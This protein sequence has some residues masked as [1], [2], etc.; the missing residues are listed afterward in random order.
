[1]VITTLLWF[2]D[3]DRKMVNTI[4]LWFWIYAMRKKFL[5]VSDTNSV[6]TQRSFFSIFAIQT[7]IRLYLQFTD[8]FETEQTRLF[9][10]KYNR[11][12]VNA[13]WF[14][15]GLITFRKDLSVYVC[16]YLHVSMKPNSLNYTNYYSLLNGPQCRRFCVI[17]LSFYKYCHVYDEILRKWIRPFD[18]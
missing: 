1:M 3:L 7:D 8:V 13:I 4:L 5:C 11:K 9:S 6:H 15:F 2:L 12:R 10:S 16:Y 14:R 17:L 18:M